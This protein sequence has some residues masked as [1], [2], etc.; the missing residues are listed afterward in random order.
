MAEVRVSRLQWKVTAVC[1]SPWWFPAWFWRLGMNSHVLRHTYL[2]T[3]TLH[4]VWP[5]IVA[6][7]RSVGSSGGQQKKQ[8]K[9][10]TNLQSKLKHLSHTWK[11]NQQ[12]VTTILECGSCTGGWHNSSCLVIVPLLKCWMQKSTGCWMTYSEKAAGWWHVLFPPGWAC[13]LR[14]TQ[15]QPSASALPVPGTRRPV[16]G[17]N[18]IFRLH[19]V[20]WPW[21]SRGSPKQLNL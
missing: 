8:N 13:T 10:T 11:H 2:T 7:E 6:A 18:D 1:W 9:K 12:K 3:L 17:A 14:C 21:I 19:V 15:Q 4:G 5:G 20:S 16:I